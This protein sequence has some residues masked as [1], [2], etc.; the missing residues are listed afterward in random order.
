MLLA[1]N[2][3]PASF[4]TVIASCTGE[5]HFTDKDEHGN[6]Q[7][8]ISSLDS[9]LGSRH[10][11]ERT[12][13]RLCHQPHNHTHSTKEY[14]RSLS[15]PI[16]RCYVVVTFSD[17]CFFVTTCTK[18]CLNTHPFGTSFEEASP[19]STTR[20][21][22]TTSYTCTHLDTSLTLAACG[23]GQGPVLLAPAAPVWCRTVHVS[24]MSNSPQKG[25]TAYRKQGTETCHTRA[26]RNIDFDW[27]IDLS[28]IF[29]FTSCNEGRNSCT[30]STWSY[31]LVRWRCLM[32]FGY[33]SNTFIYSVSSIYWTTL[34]ECW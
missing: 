32:L 27:L 25:R 6:A 30:W 11:Q 33:N 8:L 34:D 15:L 28:Y 3:F 13:K 20:T 1:S 14:S 18:N 29:L 16:T 5:P 9:P 19:L 22:R 31:G 17:L 23:Y 12:Q 26:I 7:S 2:L 10:V 4:Y 21:S 24:E